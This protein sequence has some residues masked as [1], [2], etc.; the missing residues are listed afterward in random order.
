VTDE[1]RYERLHPAELRAELERAPLAY[2]PVGTIEFHGEH[3]PFGVDSFEA[4]ALCV[5]AAERSGG[6]VLPPVYLA[7]GCLDL[8]GT[9]S[10]EPELVEAWV[11]A[12]VDRLA[13]RGFRG[14]V[15]LTG[16]G[17]LDLDHLLKRVCAEAEAAHEGLAAYALCWLELNA[18]RLT[19]PQDGEPTV[20]DHAARVET[21]W[22]LALEPDLVLLDRLADDPEAAHLGVYGRNPR[23]T[24][25][26]EFGEEQIAAAAALLA[27]RAG[28]LLAGRAV[29]PL[30]DLRA[31]VEYGWPEPPRLRGRAGEPAELLVANPGR[32]SRYV[33]AL[34]VDVDGTTLD[35]GGIVLVND[36][37]GETGIPFR[38]SELGPEHGFYLRR[39]QEARVA[40]AGIGLGPGSHRVR[41]EL[42]LGGVATLV[43]DEDVE[44]A[45]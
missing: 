43:L 3:L 13:G 42:G 14:V 12:T 10:F 32:S 17:P 27:S 28:D 29:D 5:R 4:H 2:V 18:A 9:L 26:A 6:V 33:S 30:A 7:S 1:V 15:V 45:Y 44:F 21:S 40:L 8:P 36:S 31:F 22:M 19:A 38:A 25:S 11:R 34:R 35:A 24:A 39:G 41:A 37:P 23:F 20:V 16:H